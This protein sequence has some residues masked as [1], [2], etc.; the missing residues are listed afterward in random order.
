MSGEVA[1][2]GPA[3]T[4]DWCLAFGSIDGRFKVAAAVRFGGQ[5]VRYERDLGAP[6]TV[7]AIGLLIA[8]L[9]LAGVAIHALLA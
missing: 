9:L 3:E 2:P 5:G 4:P 6:G 1:L 7:E 8:A